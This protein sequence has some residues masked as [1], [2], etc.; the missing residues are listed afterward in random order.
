MPGIVVSKDVYSGLEY[1]K[2][3]YVGEL[4]DLVGVIAYLIC[5]SHTL[6]GHWIETH[7]NI[8]LLGVTNG[9][10]FVPEDEADLIKTKGIENNADDGEN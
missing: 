6:A 7:S 1:V 5:N 2:N 10:Q 4:T 8:Y 3:T 9:F